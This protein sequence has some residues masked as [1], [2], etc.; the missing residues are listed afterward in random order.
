[1]EAANNPFNNTSSVDPTAFN[2]VTLRYNGSEVRKGDV[3]ET[4]A[5]LVALGKRNPRSKL[6]RIFAKP[7]Y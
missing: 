5:P 6:I 7:R 3:Q 1:M 4:R 2:I